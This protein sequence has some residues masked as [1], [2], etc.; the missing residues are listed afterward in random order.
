MP[1]APV[2]CPPGGYRIELHDD[3]VILHRPGRPP[4]VD[5]PPTTPSGVPITTT[6][7]D[8]GLHIEPTTITSRWDGTRLTHDDL[9]WSLAFLNA[10]LS[11]P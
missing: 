2:T 5:T 8:L 11:T 4:L 3:Q 9:S 6:N 10:G 7:L 1:L